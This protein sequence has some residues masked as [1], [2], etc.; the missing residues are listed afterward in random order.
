[1]GI[2]QLGFPTVLIYPSQGIIFENP[3]GVC[4]FKGRCCIGN[5]SA[6]SIGENG[7]LTFG[8]EFS[9]SATLK[10]VCYH[11]TSFGDNVRVRWE[12]L[13]SDTDFHTLSR[14]NGKSTKGYRSI[15][16]G[17]NNWFGCKSTILKNT[18]TP[19]YCVIASNS[20]LNNNYSY[21]NPILIGGNPCAK[22]VEGLYRDY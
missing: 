2:I 11:Y 15:R 9:A 21:S 6:V 12:N 1:M 22:I 13:F 16:I 19:N 8:K 18:Y 20:L 14:L 17:N 5:S 7:V 4:R 10:L 3:G